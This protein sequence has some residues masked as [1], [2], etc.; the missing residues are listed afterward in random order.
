[1]S[2]TPKADKYGIE[3]ANVRRSVF[4][5]KIAS[6]LVFPDACLQKGLELTTFFE[7]YNA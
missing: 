2:V 3:V 7:P 6:L 5:E 1:M 4:W